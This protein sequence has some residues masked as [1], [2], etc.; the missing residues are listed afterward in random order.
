MSFSLEVNRCPLFDFR[1]RRP[2]TR[3]HWISKRG[4][5]AE[6]F[7]HLPFIDPE[8]GDLF[9]YVPHRTLAIVPGEPER[10][11]SLPRKGRGRDGT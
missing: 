10:S 1:K 4:T 3:R 5:G 8:K 6:R 7:R 2:Y 11:E 9:G